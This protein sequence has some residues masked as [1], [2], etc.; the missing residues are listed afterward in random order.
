M[1]VC[2]ASRIRYPPTLFH[3]PFPYSTSVCLP[4]SFLTS[5]RAG[6]NCLRG[7]H[8]FMDRFLQWQ[9]VIFCC[10][11]YVRFAS[12]PRMMDIG[13]GGKV[14]YCCCRERRTGGGCTYS[15]WD[16][17]SQVLAHSRDARDQG[18]EDKRALLR[19][20]GRR[21]PNHPLGT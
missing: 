14:H 21:T 7:L 13:V 10:T 1:C 9:R 17:Q 2:Y 15:S 5:Y 19:K 8:C 16:W 20:K 6:I 12:L 18:E 3:P 4:S 11:P